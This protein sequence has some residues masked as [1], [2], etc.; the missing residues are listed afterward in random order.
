M[1]PKKSPLQKA[2]DSTVS[3]RRDAT[4]GG[5]VRGQLTTAAAQEGVENRTYDSAF[6]RM[7][8]ERKRKMDINKKSS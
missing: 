7:I 2:I 3:N 8:Q 5:T 1:P 4:N 6:D